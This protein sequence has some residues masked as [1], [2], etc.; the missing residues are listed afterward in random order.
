V[1]E[2]GYW[3]ID[4]L[5]RPYSDFT[6]QRIQDALATSGRALPVVIGPR[7]WVNAV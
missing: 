2:C 7:I 5:P 4:D 6:L 1:S 3:P